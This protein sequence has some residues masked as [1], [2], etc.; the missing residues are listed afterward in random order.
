MNGNYRQLIR[1]RPGV[2]L[3]S[4]GGRDS[5][6]IIPQPGQEFMVLADSLATPATIRGITFDGKNSARRGLYATASRLD[7]IDC[8]WMNCNT[9]IWLERC[10]EG[11]IDGN[12][13][14]D[15]SG[16]GICLDNSSPRVTR[17]TFRYLANYSVAILGAGSKPV[18]GGARSQGNDFLSYKSSVD[19]GNGTPNSIDARYNKWGPSTTVEMNVRSYP[20]NI[21]VIEDRFDDANNGPVDY[22]NWDGQPLMSRLRSEPGRLILPGG[23][24]L[25]IVVTIIAGISRRRSRVA[26]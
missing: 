23:I 14:R 3:T 2:T 6:R 1:L 26:A 15:C 10:P 9:A 24:L 18:I 11:R 21:S 5:C 19:L 4:S 8:R 25:L 13:I 22:R 16:Q 7:I 12:D 20:A 17:N